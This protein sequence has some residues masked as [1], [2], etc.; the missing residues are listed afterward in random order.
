MQLI[1]DQMETEARS[2]K[3]S[4]ELKLADEKRQIAKQFE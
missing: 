1:Q 2:Y 3:E 4:Y